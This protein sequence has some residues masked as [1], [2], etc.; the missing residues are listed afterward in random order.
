[1]C[2]LHF[3]GNYQKE[4]K[5]ETGEIKHFCFLGIFKSR[6]LISLRSILFEVLDLRENYSLNQIKSLEV[7]VI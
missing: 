5:K 6:L 7:D 4:E 2:N 3:S 1:M